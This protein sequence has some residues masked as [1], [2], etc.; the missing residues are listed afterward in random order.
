MIRRQ[1]AYAVLPA[2]KPFFAST[3]QKALQ[4]KWIRNNLD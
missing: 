3:L 2:N 4:D 1:A